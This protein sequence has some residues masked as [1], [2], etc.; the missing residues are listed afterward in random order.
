[1][2]LPP[3]DVAAAYELILGRPPENAAIVAMHAAAHDTRAALGAALLGSEEGQARSSRFAM[4]HHLVLSRLGLLPADLALLDVLA[5]QGG[6]VAEPG[7]ITD[8]LGTRTRTAFLGNPPG[9]DGRV[10]GL[11][12]PADFH[13]EAVEWVALVKAVRAARGRLRVA[14]LGA[15]WGPWT[16][17]AH[18][19]ARRCGLD[20]VRLHAV[21]ADP[22][23]FAWLG[24]HMAENAIP[25]EAL[26]LH[27]AALGDAPGD[28]LWPA[29]AG[30]ADY[31]ARPIQAQ[32]EDYRGFALE[33]ALRVPVLPIQELVARE[34][35]WDLIHM[36]LQGLEERLCRAAMPEFTARVRHVVVATHSAALD[37]AVF[38]LFHRAGWECLNNSPPRVVHRTAMRDVEGMT[39][40]DGTQFWRNAALTPA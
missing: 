24:E 37:A 8:T 10:L 4:T 27:Q 9:W 20:D 17:A 28:V 16:A 12:F 29:R 26:V 15:G 5:P 1:V 39:D 21:E 18:A 34:E 35:G 40:L 22:A 11:P 25:P 7:F 6:L 3:D 38:L 36:D 30:A 2:P 14:E 23:L 31:G 32:G 19:L 13:A 33:A